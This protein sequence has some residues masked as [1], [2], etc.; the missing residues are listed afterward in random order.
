M[1]TTIYSSEL[2]KEIRTLLS[3]Y[4]SVIQMIDEQPNNKVLI[5]ILNHYMCNLKEKTSQFIHVKQV[6]SKIGL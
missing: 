5:D 2:K 6:N 4:A 3:S 1:E